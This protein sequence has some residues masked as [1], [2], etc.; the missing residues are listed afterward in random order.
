MAKT[1][2]APN[3]GVVCGR[4]PAVPPP[5]SSAARNHT[6]SRIALA[7]GSVRWTAHSI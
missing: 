7:G 5:G 4:A 1:N 2:L 3:L 6:F